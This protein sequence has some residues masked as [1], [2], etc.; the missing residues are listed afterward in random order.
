MKITSLFQIV[1]CVAMHAHALAFNTCMHNLT[2]TLPTCTLDL[3]ITTH[4]VPP[5]RFGQ[6]LSL[7]DQ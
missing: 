5:I 2:I 6:R 7:P 1:N 3:I 4:C